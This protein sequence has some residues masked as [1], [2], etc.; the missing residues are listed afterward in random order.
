MEPTEADQCV[1]EQ[2]EE[3]EEEEGGEEECTCLRSSL[4]IVSDQASQ[5]LQ[6][7][8]SVDV[9]LLRAAMTCPGR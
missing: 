4:Q 9:M 3:E 5:P 7:L 6:A 1:V 2:G 8:E